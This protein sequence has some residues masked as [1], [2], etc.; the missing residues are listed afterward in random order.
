MLGDLGLPAMSTFGVR[1]PGHEGAGIVVKLGE[2]VTGWKVGDRAGMKP[3]CDVCHQCEL[4]WGDKECYCAKAV[5]AG[6]MR[7]GTWL[8]P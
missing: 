5:Y 1:S 4:C 2:N 7:T 8:H 3:I 6:L